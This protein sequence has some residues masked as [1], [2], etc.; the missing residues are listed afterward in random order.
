MNSQRLIY[1]QIARTSPPKSS[2]P[3]VIDVSQLTSGSYGYNH[4]NSAWET[5]YGTTEFSSEPSLK[6]SM[7]KFGDSYKSVFTS[8][9]FDYR[10]THSKVNKK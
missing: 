10:K 9:Y 4:P 3:F 5:Y 2:N 7:G 6:G 8:P 1:G